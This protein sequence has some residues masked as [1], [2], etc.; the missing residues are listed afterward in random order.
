M[1]LNVY[2]H[3]NLNDGRQRQAQVDVHR[4]WRT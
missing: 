4:R 2:G 3:V 1:G